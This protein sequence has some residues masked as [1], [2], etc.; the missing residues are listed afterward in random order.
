MESS[1]LAHYLTARAAGV[2]GVVLMAFCGSSLGSR[3]GLHGLDQWPLAGFA[4]GIIL[5][6]Q[7]PGLALRRRVDGLEKKLK[8][9]EGLQTR[10]SLERSG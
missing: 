8:E 4:V 9:V 10:H 6:G 2:V 3:L 1:T 7:A 5:L